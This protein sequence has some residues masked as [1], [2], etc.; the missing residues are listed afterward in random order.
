[1]GLIFLS[2]PPRMISTKLVM[3]LQNTGGKKVNKSQKH[4]VEYEKNT[5]FHLQLKDSILISFVLIRI[6]ISSIKTIKLMSMKQDRNKSIFL[7][8]HNLLC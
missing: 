6:K 2:M 3:L 5:Y 4:P 8:T 1:M 7:Y